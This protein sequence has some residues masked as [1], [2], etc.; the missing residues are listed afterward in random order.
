MPQRIGPLLIFFSGIL[1]PSASVNPRLGEHFSCHFGL[2]RHHILCSPAGLATGI[3]HGG[4][5]R[6]LSRGSKTLSEP[7]R[8]KSH[9]CPPLTPLALWPKSNPSVSSSLTRN[10]PVAPQCDIMTGRSHADATSTSV[11]SVPTALRKTTAK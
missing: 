11:S 7:R 1:T 8:S 9:G 3:H 2:G 4:F 10:G 6:R 5:E